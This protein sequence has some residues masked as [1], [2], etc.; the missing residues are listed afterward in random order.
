MIEYKKYR[1]YIIL[2]SIWFML[3]YIIFSQYNSIDSNTSGL[4]LVINSLHGCFYKNPTLERINSGVSLLMLVIRFIIKADKST[5]FLIVFVIVI[6][7]I[8]F[9]LNKRRKNKSD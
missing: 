7:S 4:I 2:T 1:E 9:F 5:P 6:L 8:L 3:G